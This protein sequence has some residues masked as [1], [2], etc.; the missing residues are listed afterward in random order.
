MIYWLLTQCMFSIEELESKLSDLNR[1]KIEAEEKMRSYYPDMIQKLSVS[2]A[3]HRQQIV[4][5][6]IRRIEKLKLLEKEIS[7]SN[8]NNVKMPSIEVGSSS[9]E[10]E[11]PNSEMQRNQLPDYHNDKNIEELEP[12]TS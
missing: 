7:P 12:W 4:M 10:A 11:V 5:D 6:E 9:A 2:E 3:T 8:P 1:K